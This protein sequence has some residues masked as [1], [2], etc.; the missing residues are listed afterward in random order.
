MSLLG[1]IRPILPLHLLYQS[2]KERL[3]QK[4]GEWSALETR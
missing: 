2:S 1:P 4:L 3:K